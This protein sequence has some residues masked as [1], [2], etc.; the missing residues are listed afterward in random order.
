[1]NTILNQMFTQVYF[2]GLKIQTFKLILSFCKLQK[3]TLQIYI[4]C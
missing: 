2:G 1:M 3:H 4:S